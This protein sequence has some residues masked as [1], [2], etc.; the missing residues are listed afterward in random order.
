MGHQGDSRV[1]ALGTAGLEGRHQG[2][3]GRRDIMGTACANQ[4]DSRGPTWGNSRGASGASK[5]VLGG[6]SMG[7]VGALQGH[8]MMQT[9]S[10]IVVQHGDLD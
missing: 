5:G 8:A 2:V 10:K 3:S 7:T 1:T 6:S 4:E 9:T